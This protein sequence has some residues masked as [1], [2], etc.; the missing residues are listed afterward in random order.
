MNGRAVGLILQP[1]PLRLS[2]QSNPFAATRSGLTARLCTEVLLEG[3]GERSGIETAEEPLEGGLTG[4]AWFR[5]A[6]VRKH[7]LRLLAAPLGHGQDR[8]AGTQD[9]ADR[10]S[11]DRRQWIADAGS[12]SGIRDLGEGRG[13]MVQGYRQGCGGGVATVDSMIGS[14][15]GI[16]GGCTHHGRQGAIVLSSHPARA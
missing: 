11:Q 3:L 5:K 4:G 2:I 12:P 6:R 15:V 7:V 13:H 14:L 9:R 1:A 10:Q 16:A 8:G